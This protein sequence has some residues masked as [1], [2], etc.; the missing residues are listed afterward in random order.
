[1]LRS[2][3][4]AL[5][6]AALTRLLDL[7]DLTMTA[8]ELHPPAIRYICSVPPRWPPASRCHTPSGQL[9]RAHRP[10]IR[11]LPRGSSTGY[12]RLLRLRFWYAPCARPFT[13]ALAALAPWART[14]RRFAAVP[15]ATIQ[16]IATA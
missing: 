16:A 4:N 9:C 3:F 10:T 2:G 8:L 15:P 6:P 7:E 12:L 13:E 5:G 1:M 11:D 14:I